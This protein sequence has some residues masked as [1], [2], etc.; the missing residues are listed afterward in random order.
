M[1]PSLDRPVQVVWFKRD[2]RVQDHQPLATAAE[3]GRVL[4]LYVIEPEL[5]AQPDAAW[6]HWAFIRR[7]LQTLDRDLTRLG[8]PLIVRRG[9]IAAV[10]D[11]LH[12]ATGFDTLWSHEETGNGWTFA[13][14]RRVAAWARD[15]GVEWIELPQHGVVRGLRSRDGWAGRWERRIAKSVTAVPSALTPVPGL[16][17]DPLPDRPEASLAPEPDVS[18]QPGGRDAAEETL[19][20]FLADRGKAYQGGMSSPLT[21]W[22]A[23]SRLSPHLAWGSLSLREVVHASRARVAGFQ[24]DM[25]PEAKAWRRSLRS[26]E[27]RLH[28]HC[29]FIQKLESRPSIEFRNLLPGCDGLREDAFDPERYRAWA[30]GQTGFPLVDACMRALNATGWLN[31]RMRAMLMAFAS[32]HLWLP[33]RE[34]ALHLARVFTDYEPGIHYNQVQMQSGTTGINALRIYNPVKQSFDQDPKGIF[35]RRWVPE[36]QP[37]PDAF[38]HEP[39]LMPDDLQRATGVHIGRDYPPPIVDHIAAAREAR[40]RLIAVRRQPESRAESRDI[41]QKMGSRRGARRRPKAPSPQTD[42]WG[43]DQGK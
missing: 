35:I 10:L 39:W 7:C 21:A 28:W 2:L 40:Q 27:E 9:E 32:Y 1:T 13:R 19:G 42:L 24:G 18:L 43:S 29:H 6:R 38:I 11:E 37:V 25:S 5:W 36:L 41:Q 30:Q 14:D 20:S 23:C 17:T 34:P 26:F 22:D 4:P 15:R 16:R 12:R 3:R 8:Q 33:W 31:F